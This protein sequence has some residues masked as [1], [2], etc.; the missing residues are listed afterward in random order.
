MYE[1]PGATSYGYTSMYAPTANIWHQQRAPVYSG[2]VQPNY[3]Y[4]DWILGD[5]LKLVAEETRQKAAIF[6]QRQFATTRQLRF[7]NDISG[8]GGPYPSS[9]ESWSD[10]YAYNYMNNSIKTMNLA[11]TSALLVILFVVLFK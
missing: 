5:R 7:N 6:Q 9:R 10:N 8:T 1:T 3:N 2:A 11:K 4:P